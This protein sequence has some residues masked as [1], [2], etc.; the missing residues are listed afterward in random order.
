MTALCLYL[1]DVTL[2]ELKGA[3]SDVDTF[4]CLNMN[5]VDTFV[6]VVIVHWIVWRQKNSFVDGDCR[7]TLRCKK[8]KHKDNNYSF[9]TNKISNIHKYIAICLLHV[10]FMPHQQSCS[11]TG[12][13]WCARGW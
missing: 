7:S 9:V 10:Q 1:E 4:A 8:N 13:N 3:C 12:L 2:C 11:N 5:A 6:A